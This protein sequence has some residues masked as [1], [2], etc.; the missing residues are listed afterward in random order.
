MIK[1]LYK[2]QNEKPQEFY[3]RLRGRWGD[4]YIVRPE[5]GDP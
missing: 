2:H 1:S 4:I 3:A 5:R